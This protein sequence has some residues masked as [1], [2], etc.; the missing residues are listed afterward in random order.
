MANYVKYGSPNVDQMQAL[1]S[2]NRAKCYPYGSKLFGRPGLAWAANVDAFSKVGGLIDY[3]IL[4]AGDWYMAYG[5]V[6]AIG[7][8]S[9]QHFSPAHAKKLYA[10]QDRA[11][12]WIKRDVGYISG[13][14]FHDWHGPKVARGY[15]TRGS[16]LF[17]NEYDPDI[18]VKYDAQG[19][20]QLE[21]VTPR[22]IKMR[23]QIRAYFRSRN[24]D[25]TR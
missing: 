8:T 14:M 11:E 7:A 3:S 21:T 19:L 25:A 24:E 12:H 13:T 4:G 5:L 1:E 6:G 23:D 17:D 22:Q 15:G 9:A 10:W 18:D 16:I 20:L 2:D